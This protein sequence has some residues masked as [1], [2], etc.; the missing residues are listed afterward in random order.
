MKPVVSALILAGVPSLA[1]V[2][3]ARAAPAYDSAK[4]PV[5]LSALKEIADIAVSVCAAAEQDGY[6]QTE[7][8]V[9]K[10]TA[11]VGKLTQLVVDAST[12]TTRQTVLVRWQGVLQ[13]DIANSVKQTNEC[14][15]NVVTSLQKIVFDNTRAPE[16]PPALP[17]PPA[18]PQPVPPAPQVTAPPAS[19][20]ATLRVFLK[21]NLTERNLAVLRTTLPG[22]DIVTGRS[23]IDKRNPADILFVNRDQV[24]PAEVL[25]VAG[26]LKE[27]GVPIKSVQQS[28]TVKGREIQVGTYPNRFRDKKAL[29]LDALA[30]LEGP[31]FW[32]AAFNGQVFCSTGIG[33]GRQCEAGSDGRPVFRRA[34]VQN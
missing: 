1:P 21:D 13:S 18:R 3:P 25:Y 33:T 19:G 20:R 23:T 14:R 32:T 16:R 2:V 31:A 15:Y 8:V 34:P 24:S 10:A 26:A 7:Q 30:R 29:D 4:L 28:T 22:F 11:G 17:L 27:M 5:V 6:Q 12:E 9:Q